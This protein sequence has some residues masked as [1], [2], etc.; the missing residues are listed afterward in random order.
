MKPEDIVADWLHEKRVALVE[1]YLSEGIK[2]S[3]R[4]ER[5]LVENVKAEGATIRG[6]L[7]GEDY[8]EYI[9]NGR[10]PNANQSPEALRRWVGYMGN[11]P[12]AQW[13]KDKGLTLS[14]FAVAY[15]IA[16]EGV[17]V[18]N[19]HNPGDLISRVVNQQAI[20]ELNK[21]LSHASVTSA[22]SEIR[23]ILKL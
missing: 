5:A 7:T 10:R 18:P 2:A 14:P 3:G 11:G 13:V 22:T 12:I 8:T 1:V 23:N 4:W 17:R 21:R 15:K 19:Q 20:D 9:Q 16:R 6:T